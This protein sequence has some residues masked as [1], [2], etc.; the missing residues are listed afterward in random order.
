MQLGAQVCF[1]ILQNL[2]LYIVQQQQTN[3]TIL[4]QV[5][6]KFSIIR[7]TILFT[8]NIQYGKADDISCVLKGVSHIITN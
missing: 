2:I 8:R 7:K 6:T 5:R 4:T 1:N 3:K